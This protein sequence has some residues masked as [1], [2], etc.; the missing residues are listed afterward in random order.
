MLETQKMKAVSIPQSDLILFQMENQQA[1]TSDTAFLVDTVIQ[2]YGQNSQM[3]ILDAGTG[4]GIIAF[5]LKK[6]FSRWQITGIDV[7]KS[8][9]DLAKNNLNLFMQYYPSFHLNFIHQDLRHYQRKDFDLILCNPP[10][11]KLNQARLA[12][13]PEKAIAR[14]E[15]ELTMGDIFNFFVQQ[16]NPFVKIMILYPDFRNQE[17]L[18]LTKKLNLKIISQMQVPNSR[19]NNQV[20]L[21]EIGI[22]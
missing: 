13:N 18:N 10:Y 21:Y 19:P 2:K 12:K 11:Y 16:Q 7:Q 17:L 22:C 5:M 4:S 8:V 1:V 9:I 3:N 6:H 20:F 14:H 15:V